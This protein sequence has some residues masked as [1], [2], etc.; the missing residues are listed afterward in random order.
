[1]VANLSTF[2]DHETLIQAWRL[3]LDRLPED[4]RNAK[5]LLAGKDFGTQ[6]SLKRLTRELRLE[7]DVLFLGQVDDISGLLQSVDLGV[8]SSRSEGSPNG[9]LEC[10]Q[11]GLAIVATDLEGTR[12]AF[13]KYQYP[14]LASPDNPNQFAQN[15][16]TLKQDLILRTKIGIYNRDRVLIEYSPEKMCKSTEALVAG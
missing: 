14:W 5:L 3:V 11:A 8:H 9:V 15:I 12:E 6:S 10:M 16:L 13:E 1:M 2:K 4:Q 7:D